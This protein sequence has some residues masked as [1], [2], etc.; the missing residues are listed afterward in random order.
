MLES[1]INWRKKR[2]KLSFQNLIAENL[3]PVWL[4]DRGAYVWMIT[5]D[6]SIRVT[7]DQ[8]GNWIV[9]DGLKMVSGY[10][11]TADQA[12]NFV[13]LYV[14]DEIISKYFKYLNAHN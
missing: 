5:S 11:K 6:R 14:A 9:Y 8:V 12:K 2:K 4:F 13:V 7:S 1:Y 10:M 3:R